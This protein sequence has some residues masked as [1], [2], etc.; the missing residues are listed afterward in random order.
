MLF[1][2]LGP[3][4]GIVFTGIDLHLKF[5]LST[6]VVDDTS[7]VLPILLDI[8]SYFQVILPSFSIYLFPIGGQHVKN[9]LVI[10]ALDPEAP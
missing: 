4:L 2:D 8:K 7:L 10:Y 6:V 1:G 9:K 5:D 3:S